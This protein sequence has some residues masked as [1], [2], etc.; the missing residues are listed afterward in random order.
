MLQLVAKLYPTVCCS[1][2]GKHI[3]LRDSY[4]NNNNVC[5]SLLWALGQGGYYDI[6]TGIKGLKLNLIVFF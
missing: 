3:I 6:N 1:S 5:L 2:L 4:K